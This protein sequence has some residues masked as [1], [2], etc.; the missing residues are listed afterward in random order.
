MTFET[1]SGTP[2]VVQPRWFFATDAPRP[3]SGQAKQVSQSKATNATATAS[4]SNASS[5]PSSSQ[6]Q[7]ATI[8]LSSVASPSTTTA[9][10]AAAAAAAVAASATETSAQ[11]A[12]AA[13]ASAAAPSPVADKQPRPTNWEP[14]T[15]EDSRELE[16]AYQQSTAARA[17]ARSE[18]RSPLIE[19]QED[20][21][22]EVDIRARLLRPVYWRGNAY[23][24]RRALWFQLVGNKYEPCEENLARQIEDGYLKHRPW[25]LEFDTSANGTIRRAATAPVQDSPHINHAPIMSSS[26]TAPPMSASNAGTNNGLPPNT[27]NGPFLPKWPLLGPYMGQSVIF[28]ATCGAWLLSGKFAE[29]IVA[30][31]TKGENMGGIK[32]VRGWDEVERLTQKADKLKRDK[33]TR[34]TTIDSSAIRPIGLQ[35]ELDDISS[36]NTATTITG[37][38]GVSND[39]TSDKTDE[40]KSKKRDR[41]IEH[42]ILVVHGIG[43]KLGEKTDLVSIVND[44]N[45]LRQGMKD[46]AT[47]AASYTGPNKKTPNDPDLILGRGV[48]VLPVEW[49]HKINFGAGGEYSMGDGMFGG[50]GMDAVD[51]DDEEDDEDDDNEEEDNNTI[52]DGQL[53]KEENNNTAI[54][55]AQHN[56][57]DTDDSSDGDLFGG[58]VSRKSA[59]NKAKRRQRR[60][61]R[62]LLAAQNRGYASLPSLSGITLDGIPAIRTLVSDVLLDVLL[63]MTP[64]YRRQM[65]E[66]LIDEVNRIYRLFIRRNPNF[67]LNGGQISILGHSLGSVLSFD[68]L[69]AQRSRAEAWMQLRGHVA[70]RSKSVHSKQTSIAD[71]I[72]TNRSSRVALP[73]LEFPV[74]NLFALGS[75]IGLFLLLKGSALRPRG[76][77]GSMHYA[78]TSGSDGSGLGSRLGPDGLPHTQLAQPLIENLYN[79]YHRADPISYRIEPL[80]DPSHTRSTPKPIPYTKGGLRGLH[81]GMQ[82]VGSGIA[83]RAS[84]MFATMRTSI[85]AVSI[86][87]SLGK[88]AKEAKEATD[89]DNTDVNDN[90]DRKE[91]T[92]V[93]STDPRILLQQLN[94]SGRVDWCLQ[95]GVLENEYLTGLQVHF[96]YW[97]DADIAAFLLRECTRNEC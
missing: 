22:F 23:E 19:V 69:C 5:P 34:T 92:A 87:K 10:A 45:I 75:P 46:P 13:A 49:R 9:T 66:A 7:P 57:N 28:T 12:A 40:D 32:L 88:E 17:D 43:Q 73:L 84:T 11:A 63:Y 29:T 52:Q 64:K 68:I 60:A 54:Q 74:N 3:H 71:S 91:R 53:K 15:D 24:V 94:Y 97:S 1:T 86:F 79:I 33:I 47:T 51:I 36:L 95:E 78:Y 61:Q 26:A 2:P 4:K 41:K 21:L 37:N 56:Y 89:D 81:L 70:Q 96:N 42:L 65:Y 18:D 83:G 62:R 80:V 38:S 59:D 82:E 25:L 76:P 90:E 85:R 27:T 8:T 48:Q 20:R 58:S 50:V 14:F 55:D 31:F 77:D 44:C 16:A 93:M 30:K 67:L 72:A 35:D 39:T 6:S